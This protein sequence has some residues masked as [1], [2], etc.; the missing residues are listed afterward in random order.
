MFTKAVIIGS[1]NV[2]W[3]LA[4]TLPL[5]GVCVMQIFS[6]NTI[7]AEALAGEIGADYTSEY[8]EISSMADFYIYAISDDAL[9]EVITNIPTDNG[10][11]VHTSGS[12]DISVFENT[13]TNY[14]VIYPLQTFSRN[15]KIEFGKVAFFIEANNKP[16]FER[17]EALTKKL[18][19]KIFEVDSKQR[20]RVHLAG[21]FGNNFANAMWSIADDILKEQNIPFVDAMMPMIEESVAKLKYMPPSMAQTG[22]AKRGDHNTMKAHSELLGNETIVLNIY[23]MLSEFI[24][25]KG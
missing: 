6:R 25:H 17:I 4:H 19:L 1:G 2:A 8:S 24:E 20:R 5:Y 11:H 21:V 22:P 15:K 23:K 16:T 7:H 3:Q 9:T 12:V 18:S 10:V 13:K 14:G